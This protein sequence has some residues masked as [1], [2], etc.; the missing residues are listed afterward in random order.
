MKKTGLMKPGSPFQKNLPFSPWIYFSI[1]L[2][3]NGLLSY[4][5][6]SF[7]AKLWI[8]FL[9]LLVPLA[10]GLK[11]VLDERKSASL[12][13]GAHLEP[14]TVPN[15]AWV[16]F[17][18]LLLFTR[19]YRLTSLPSWPLSD[20]GIEAFLG[21]GLVKHWSWNLL[22]APARAEP[23][24][25]WML[26]LYFKLIPPSFF[27]LRFFPLVVS[28]MTVGAAYWA[29]RQFLLQSVSFLMAW[30]WA[31]SFGEFTLARF[32][33]LV[34]LVPLFQCLCFG[35]LG[36]FWASPNARSRWKNFLV[37]CFLAGI[38]F[39]TWT[40]WAAVWLCLLVLLLVHSLELPSLRGVFPLAF[41]VLSGLMALPLVLARLAPG[42]MSHIQGAILLAP[43]KTMPVYLEALF[44]GESGAFP[45]GS[46]WGGFLN[47][48]LGAWVFL[49]VLHLV[50]TAARVH[51]YLASSFFFLALLPA[52]VSNGLEIYRA[53]P[54]LPF[55]MVLAA[56]GGISLVPR[57]FSVARGIGLGLLMSGSLALDLHNYVNHYCRSTR[58][59]SAAYHHAYQSLEALHKNSGPLYI[60]AEFNTNYDDKTLNIACYSFNCVQNPD[61]AQTHP[62]WAAL[63][64]N[65]NYAP[66]L[67]RRFEGVKL[68]ALEPEQETNEHLPFDLFLVPV[69]KIPKETLDHWVQADRIYNQVDLEVKN[70]NPLSSWGDYPDSFASLRGRFQE[71]PLLTSVYWEKFAFFKF[72]G[73]DFESAAQAYQNAIQQGIPA[74]HLYYDL[75]ICLRL[76]GR[77]AEAQKAFQEADKR[78][79]N[80]F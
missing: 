78:A 70:K 24:M 80:P 25:Y 14:F 63:I 55:L 6:L 64:L 79:Q 47:P 75:G 50:R 33:S 56:W 27:S 23:L 11:S 36:R 20:E 46:N 35:W 71:D 12:P 28:L 72:L 77:V 73:K 26:G 15:W 21:M 76:T 45:F 57:P 5:P 59:R 8:G 19:F 30:L 53:L 37:L 43:W 62:Q 31:F 65:S 54:L 4:F 32:C 58:M 13:G 42:E 17:G 69:S 3:S 61:P 9:G 16:L 34:I 66:Y 74:A 18:S 10:A 52:M 44:W 51:L 41:T 68:E 67:L 22:W 39:Y 1:F 29:A 2:V 49:G 38:G 48:V 60:F 40:N 7:Q